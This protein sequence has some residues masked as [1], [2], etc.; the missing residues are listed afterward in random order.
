MSTT[1]SVSLLVGSEDVPVWFAD[2][3]ENAIN[4]GNASIDAVYVTDGPLGSAASDRGLRFLVNDLREKGCWAPV[5]VGRKVLRTVIGTIPELERTSIKNIRSIGEST[6][7]TTTAIENEENRYSFDTEVVAAIKD[8]DIAVHWGIGILTGE[9]LTAPELGIWGFH[10]GDIREY[11][12]GPPGFWE[13][14]NGEVNAAATLQRYTESLDA[15]YIVSEESVP[16]SDAKTWREV[17]RRLCLACTELFQ[18]AIQ[19]LNEG[20]FELSSPDQFGTVYSP[21]DRD[22][23][24]TLLYLKRSIPGWVRTVMLEERL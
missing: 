17:R 7:Q 15:G 4:G 10:Q 21:T 12:G 20:D 9:V 1:P 22:C 3:I 11:R 5:Q 2:A 23:A 14:V 16:I 8:T 13:Y 18:K 24:V 19:S 6:V